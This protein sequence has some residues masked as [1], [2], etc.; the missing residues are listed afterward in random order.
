MLIDDNVPELTGKGF[1]KFKGFLEEFAPDE[2]WIYV[3]RLYFPNNQPT[4]TYFATYYCEQ[5]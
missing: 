1:Q 5:V 3:Y 4:P 2:N